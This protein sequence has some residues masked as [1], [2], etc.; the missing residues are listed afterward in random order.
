MKIII[1]YV[2]V[3]LMKLFC[4]ASIPGLIKNL[5]ANTIWIG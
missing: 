3:R 4:S 2:E 1:V 5:S